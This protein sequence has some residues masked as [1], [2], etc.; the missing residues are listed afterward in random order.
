ML[1]L[2]KYMKR[3]AHTSDQLCPLTDDDLKRLQNHLLGMFLDIARVCGK[4]GIRGVLWGWQ[5]AGGVCSRAGRGGG[6]RG[7]G[8]G[9]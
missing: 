5:T 4:P 2:S 1:R 3:L 7:R 9:G 8:A 6:R